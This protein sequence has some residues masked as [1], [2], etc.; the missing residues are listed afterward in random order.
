[1]DCDNQMRNGKILKLWGSI[2]IQEEHLRLFPI[3]F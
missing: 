2:A 3:F 1:M